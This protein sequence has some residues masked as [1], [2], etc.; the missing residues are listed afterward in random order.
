MIET[1]DSIKNLADALHKVQG[2]V[3]GVAR[4][5]ENPFLKSKYAN[6]EAVIATIRTPLQAQGI[7]FTQAPGAFRDGA[8]EVTTQ[9][10]HAKSGEY[11]RSTLSIPLPKADPQS[12]GSAITYGCRY[13]LMAMIGVPPTDDDGEAATPRGNGSKKSA[14]QTRKD[15]DYPKIEKEIRACKSPKELK[16]W[17]LENAERIH[18]LG[19]GW[20]EHARE[21]YHRKMSQ[22]KGDEGDSANGR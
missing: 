21:E 3:T 5:T 8:L 7:V 10:T 15:G 16:T 18:S 22:L 17:G 1:S 11:M 13:S 20:D 2:E 6:L 9:L 14:Y 12:A 19:G 4:N